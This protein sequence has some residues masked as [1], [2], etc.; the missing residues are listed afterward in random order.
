M[1]TSWTCASGRSRRASSCADADG[2]AGKA[3]GLGYL[4]MDDAEITERLLADVRLLRLPLVRNGNLC[5]AGPAEATW[6]GWL[7]A[8]GSS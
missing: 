2:T 3:A 1:S 5:T 6:K 7:A 4:R 8:S